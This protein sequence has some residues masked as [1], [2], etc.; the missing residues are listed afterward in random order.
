MLLIVPVIAIGIFLIYDYLMAYKIDSRVI[1]NTRNVSEV[2][3]ANN[4]AHMFDY[5]GIMA[6]LDQNIIRSQ[7]MALNHQVS[8]VSIEID[9][10]SLNDQSNFVDAT[11]MAS[12]N[13][14]TIEAANQIK[15]LIIPYMGT[16]QTRE[17]IN[18]MKHFEKNAEIFFDFRNQINM[19]KKLK[20]STNS[21]SI[22]L[23]V[24]N[25]IKIKLSEL[26]KSYETIVQ[27]DQDSI[28][29]Q[30]KKY[31]LLINESIRI[32]DEWIEKITLLKRMNN[33]ISQIRDEI[34][35]L[36]SE[37]ARKTIELKSEEEIQS[38]KMQKS[39][40]IQLL[41]TLEEEYIDLIDSIISEKNEKPKL[42]DKIALLSNQIDELL[43]DLEP[44]EN[45]KLPSG[46]S[47]LFLSDD[48]NNVDVGALDGFIYDEYCLSV[49][50]S[51]DKGSVRNFN[52][53]GTKYERESVINGEIEYL[54]AGKNSD[55]QNVQSIKVRLLAIRA[56][57]NMIH[58][59]SNT[60]KTSQISRTTS[61]LPT[62]WNGVAYSALVTLWSSTEAYL[63]MITL[64]KGGG[65][66]FIKKEDEW[67][68]SFDNLMQGN[69]S[70]LNAIKDNS[71]SHY[72]DKRLFY[73]DYL[74]IMLYVQPK[75]VTVKRSMILLD[76]NIR[77]VSENRFDLAQF[78]MGHR[79]DLSYLQK[80][81]DNNRSAISLTNKY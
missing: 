77:K 15:A 56:I 76:A 39:E 62:P 67:V 34:S 29:K 70:N 41:T 63:D 38:L 66:H 72:L 74:R 40:C 64:Y 50:K 9:H 33:N 80:G 57:A 19:I 35:D 59:S 27:S 18:Q 46:G 68:L 61:A 53:L 13:I 36:K 8:D 75:E 14:I 58:I 28:E 26:H 43:F 22:L 32:K 48:M 78:S 30:I 11:M 60:S 2:Q 16:G 54:V 25:D 73:Q 12:R 6:Y 44:I 69:F 21:E 5:Y 45:L 24:E 55:P 51:F 10:F 79:I 81:L 71:K 7:F 4:N 65:H 49:L 47:D 1:K 42:L 37:I 23:N 31:E 17:L 52:P 3:L 20:F